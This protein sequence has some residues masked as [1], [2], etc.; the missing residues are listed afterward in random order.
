[1]THERRALAASAAALFAASF[2]VRVPLA[3]AWSSL[4]VLE[5]HDVIF[6][7]DPVV[8]LQAFGDGDMRDRMWRAHP[9]VRNLVN[10]PVRLLAAGVR[11]VRPDWT[12]EQARRQVA[13]LVAPAASGVTTALLFLTLRLLGATLGAALAGA[14]IEMC[15]FSGLVFG[16]VPESYPLSGAVLAAAF[17]LL[18]DALRGG[19]LRALAWVVVASTAFGITTT[20]LG[21]VAILLFLAASRTIRSLPRAAGVTAAVLALSVLVAAAEFFAVNAVYDEW[22]PL[23][24]FERTDTFL[25]PRAGETIRSFPRAVVS[26]VLPDRPAVVTNEISLRRDYPIKLRFT[27]EDG[28][29]GLASGLLRGLVVAGFLL[30]GA[31]QLARRDGMGR[32]ILGAAAGVLAFNL[33]LHSAYRGPDLLLYSMHWHPALALVLG[34]TALAPRRAAALLLA[35]AVAFN[36]AA[37]LWWML[38]TLRAMS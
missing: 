5:Q 17:L 29:Q 13:L 35:V 31:M 24:K 4:G 1:V 26:T 14:L 2:L 28:P 33:V 11:L 36:N 19:R 12:V 18:A 32:P 3:R 23:R 16:S 20:N 22:V 37:V 15:G 7:A 8:Y 30:L 10:P 9:N 34:A 27:M 6:D 21:I 38:G 25:A